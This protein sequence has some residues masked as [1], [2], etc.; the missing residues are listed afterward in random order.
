LKQRNAGVPRS[1]IVA[2][3]EVGARRHRIHALDL[4][5]G[6]RAGET[7]AQPGSLGFEDG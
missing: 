1:G 4:D 3:K 6:V 7:H 2:D 5:A